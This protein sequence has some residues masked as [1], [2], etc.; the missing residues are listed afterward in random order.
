MCFLVCMLW[1]SI[2][3]Y[4]KTKTIKVVADE[5][6]DFILSTFI[7]LAIGPPHFWVF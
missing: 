7:S 1:I 2:I 5:K 6:N 4:N 3:L